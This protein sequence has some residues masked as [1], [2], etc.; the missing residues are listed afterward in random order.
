MEIT[1]YNNKTNIFKQLDIT[2]NNFI[3]SDKP[4]VNLAISEIGN[5]KN[6]I[7]TTDEFW[8]FTRKYFKNTGELPLLDNFKGV[9]AIDTN[10]LANIEENYIDEFIT[11]TSK[12]GSPTSFLNFVICDRVIENPYLCS[13]ITDNLSFFSETSNGFLPIINI[14]FSQIKYQQEFFPLTFNM[15]LGKSIEIMHFLSKDFDIFN[16]TH[17]RLLYENQYVYMIQSIFNDSP[18]GDLNAT[19]IDYH[20]RQIIRQSLEALDKGL[21]Y[22]EG[23]NVDFNVWMEQR[24]LK[25]KFIENFRRQT[26]LDIEIIRNEVINSS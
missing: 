7:E 11:N 2:A 9:K 22:T 17:T 6:F 13:T 24:A 20:K 3:E 5:G 19:L 10:I 8:V 23:S 26:L 15:H 25:E 18:C 4:H 12:G 16:N 1:K 14:V 21:F